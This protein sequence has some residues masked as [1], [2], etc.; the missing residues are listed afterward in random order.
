MNDTVKS[1]RFWEPLWQ[2]YDVWPS[3]VLC[4]VPELEYASRLDVRGR[5][6]DHCC[7]NGVFAA[8]AWPDK[9]VEAGC[10]FNAPS[11]AKAECGNRY[12]RLDTCDVSK[13]LPYEDASFDLI[14]N[15]SALE[16]I[17]HLDATLLEVARV[18][19]PDGLFAFNVLNHR[20][21]EWWPL[22]PQTLHEYR[23]WQPFIHALNL[24]EWEQR[25]AAAGLRLTAMAGYFDVSAARELARLEYRF[26]QVELGRLANASVWMI[27]RFPGLMRAYWKR[28]LAGLVWKTDPDAGAGFFIQ[29]QHAHA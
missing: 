26:S 1:S 5:L 7:G 24:Q 12:Q 28:R 9:I 8:M 10:D 11:L 21:F 13:Q 20:Y 4:R 27:R 17:P 25:L 16:H 18:L 22:S 23:Q 3:L 19:K 29:A 2:T 15:N 6:L 14:F